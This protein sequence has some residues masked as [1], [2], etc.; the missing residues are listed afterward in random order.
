MMRGSPHRRRKVADAA[1][2]VLA[3]LGGHGLSHRAV[4]AEAGLPPGT[5]SNHFNSR[6][7]LLLA[8]AERLSETHWEYVETL[9]DRLDGPLDR[10]R[11]A[12]LL[13]RLVTG[14]DEEA[15]VRLVARYELFLAGVREPELQP[16]LTRI[17]A[18]A[19]EAA[20]IILDSA[21]LPEPEAHVGLLSSV[22]TGL[23]FDHLTAP[24]EL[25]PGTEPEGT[26]TQVLDAIFGPVRSS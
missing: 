16:A 1:V 11:L 23:A 22:L 26:T 14:E 9:R 25:R 5:T 6:Q 12:A 10:E 18:A 17:R 20:S 19:L 3:R 8:A 13:Q 2:Q 15:R 21:G 24:P 4:D 7:A